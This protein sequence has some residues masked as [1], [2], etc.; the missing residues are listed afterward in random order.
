ME[1]E[2]TYINYDVMD[3]DTQLRKVKKTLKQEGKITRNYCLRRFIS[4]LSAIIFVLKEKGWEFSTRRVYL[5]PNKKSWDFV[6]DVIK[7]G[8]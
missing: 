7:E 5:D 1:L 8:N 6:Y 4:R 2:G 3:Y